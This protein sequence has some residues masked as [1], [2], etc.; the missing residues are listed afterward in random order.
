M[1]TGTTNGA[2]RDGADGS[3]G[4]PRARPAKDNEVGR[5]RCSSSTSSALRWRRGFRPTDRQRER[6][7]HF[8]FDRLRAVN[9]NSLGCPMVA[10]RLAAVLSL[11]REK[12]LFWLVGWTSPSSSSIDGDSAAQ[13][14]QKQRTTSGRG[15]QQQ[16]VLKIGC[17]RNFFGRS[18]RLGL[19][20]AARHRAGFFV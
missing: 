1:V 20:M 18:T 19:W 14:S 2:V 7:P 13:H 3:M 4:G 10:C 15:Q 11:Y 9:Y 6:E 12:D 16:R 8:V 17:L 5:F